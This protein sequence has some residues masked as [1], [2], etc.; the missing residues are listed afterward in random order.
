MHNVIRSLLLA[1]ALVCAPALAVAQPASATLT[2]KNGARTEVLSKDQIAALPHVTVS[3]PIH[4]TPHVFEG[5]PLT[6]L[7]QRIGAPAGEA[8][9]GEALASVVVVRARDAYTVALA[10]AETDASMRKDPII[11]ADRMDGAAIPDAEGPYRLVA[12][13]DLRPARSAKMVE[14]LEIKSLKAP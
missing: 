14:S 1:A 3:M 2:L 9:H 10:L 11:L 7:L 8:L 13:A 5:V 12:V 6:V 4:G